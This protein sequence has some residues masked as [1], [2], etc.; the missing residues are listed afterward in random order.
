MKPFTIDM[1]PGVRHVRTYETTPLPQQQPALKLLHRVF[2]C[3]REEVPAFP[4]PL[5]KD[6]IRE[7]H[8][9][10]TQTDPAAVGSVVEF[11]RVY[12]AKPATYFELE[13]FLASTYIVSSRVSKTSTTDFVPDGAKVVASGTVPIASWETTFAYGSTIR[14]QKVPG[15]LLLPFNYPSPDGTAGSKNITNDSLT[16]K[17]VSIWAV[18]EGQEVNFY[19]PKK[20]LCR[21]FYEFFLIGDVAWADYTDKVNIP[22]FSRGDNFTPVAGYKAVSPSDL[23][24]WLDLG[25]IYVRITKVANNGVT[26]EFEY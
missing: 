9:F 5:T 11:E 13:T 1:R 21:K 22:L 16:P 8:Y 2:R 19:T 17:P 15:E 14:Q 24:P 26:Q 12:S 6:S 23:E 20:L 7:D 10:L 18:G 4:D 25:N 3:R